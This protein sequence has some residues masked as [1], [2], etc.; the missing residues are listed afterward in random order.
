MSIA[1]TIIF[2]L[3]LMV[4][5]LSV[6]TGCQ[7]TMTKVLEP[8]MGKPKTPEIGIQKPAPNTSDTESFT[9][10]NLQ[11]DL[12]RQAQEALQNIYF[13]FNKAIILPQSETQLKI[14]GNFMTGH[15]VVRILIAGN[16]DERGSNEYNIGLG[17]RRASAVKKFLAAFGIPEDR[18][19][20]TSYGK[21]RLAVQGCTDEPCHAKNRRD[22][23]TVLQNKGQPLSKTE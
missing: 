16:C 15:P 12:L 21:E 17:E 7:K 13:D 18:F 14:I 3:L 19:E 1:K 4:M 10:A 8:S 22:E 9:E 11:G 6:L 2:M 23:F 5:S 20:T